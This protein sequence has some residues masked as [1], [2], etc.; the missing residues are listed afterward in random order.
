M[1]IKLNEQKGTTLIETIIA[2]ALLSVIL[3][4]AVAFYSVFR[5]SYMVQIATIQCQAS[6]RTAEN[7]ILS[8]M[9]R[10][11]Q[12]EI[13]SALNGNSLNVY[14]PSGE[15]N[16][17]ANYDVEYNDDNNIYELVYTKNGDKTVTAQYIDIEADDEGDVGGFIVKNNGD[18][19]I[20]FTINTKQQPRGQRKVTFQV[21]AS[22]R[23]RV[24]R[25]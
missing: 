24:D 7:H 1:R 2:I 15:G 9:R 16:I 13:Y 8:N 14:L 25:Q 17:E 12:S 18:G 10:S 22:H 20:S 23:I 11:D 19:V 21:K 4:V 3:L 5:G 6:A